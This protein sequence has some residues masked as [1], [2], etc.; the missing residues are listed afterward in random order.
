MVISRLR[1][2]VTYSSRS[3]WCE[4]QWAISAG[5]VMQAELVLKTLFFRLLLYS[6]LNFIIEIGSSKPNVKKW[7]LQTVLQTEYESKIRN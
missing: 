3:R 4:V 5:N 7:V 1:I 6:R 2:L